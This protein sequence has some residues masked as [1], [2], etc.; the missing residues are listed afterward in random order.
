MTTA[1]PTANAFGTYTVKAQTAGGGEVEVGVQASD[2]GLADGGPWPCEEDG[3]PSP[4]VS[5]ALLAK[6]RVRVRVR[7]RV[8][9]RVR[10]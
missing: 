7:I 8:R 9:V 3:C 4:T 6:V 5:C 1:T 2:P 10:V